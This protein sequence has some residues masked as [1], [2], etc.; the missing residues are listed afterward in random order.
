MYKE[1]IGISRIEISF[2]NEHTHTLIH[3]IDIHTIY[4]HTEIT[5][6]T[7]P[8]AFLTQNRKLMP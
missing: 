6:E 2:S 5:L 4:T 1:S 7:L 8:V 3:Y